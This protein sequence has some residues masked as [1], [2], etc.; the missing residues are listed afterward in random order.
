MILANKKGLEE[1][2]KFTISTHSNIHS[3]WRI[4]NLLKKKKECGDLIHEDTCVSEIPSSNKRIIFFDI[5]SAT[6]N[7]GGICEFG[8]LLTNEKFEILEQR[9]ILINPKCEFSWRVLKKVLKRDKRVYE[10]QKGLTS[11]YDFI[12]KLITGADLVFGFATIN[13]VNYLNSDFRRFNLK[14]IDYNFYDIQKILGEFYSEYKNLSLENSMNLLEVKRYGKLHD[15][16]YDALNSMLILKKISEALK[17]SVTEIVDLTQRLMDKC[18]DG[19][20]ESLKLRK[21]KRQEQNQRKDKKRLS[22]N[23]DNFINS[24]KFEDVFYI[25]AKEGTNVD[26]LLKGLS[27]SLEEGPMYYP[28]DQI[29]NNPQSFVIS[30]LIREK[31]L[32]LTK[33]EVPH[34]I[35]VVV[36]SMNRDEDDLLNIHA[37]I[38]VERSSQKKIIIGSKGSMIKQIGTLARKE[39]VMLLGEK[40]YLELWVKVEEGWRDKQFLLKQ[41]GYNKDI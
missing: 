8:Y 40:I 37:A 29:T 33:E 13:D 19:E 38:I 14:P 4:L 10:A 6:G 23:I 21:I 26:K 41:Y 28:E 36:E 32:L 12:R 34:S 24:Y 2:G 35:A 18:Y 31:V 15:A 30:E 17:L 25:S 1:T 27:N 3:D 16:G 20:I 5:E 7:V 9:N 22:K 11:H 39:I